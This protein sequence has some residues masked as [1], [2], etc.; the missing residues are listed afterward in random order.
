MGGAEKEEKEEE[1]R[2]RADYYGGN[3]KGGNTRTW[4]IKESGKILG[5]EMLSSIYHM[6]CLRC[7]KQTWVKLTRRVGIIITSKVFILGLPCARLR[8]TITKQTQSLPSLNVA[9]RS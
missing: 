3:R 2:Q 8:D 4:G 6:F 9:E 1:A 7:L 5:G